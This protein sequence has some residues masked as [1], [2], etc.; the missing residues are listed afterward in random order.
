MSRSLVR[1]DAGFKDHVNQLCRTCYHIFRNIR[2]IRK[3]ITTDM[4]NTLVKSLVLNQLDYCNSIL[5]GLPDSEIRKLQ[6]VQNCAAKLVLNLKW[7]ES[8]SQ[9]L[10]TLNWLPIRKRIDF[11]IAV[12]VFK[13]VNNCAPRY[14]QELL[15]PLS[16]NRMSRSTSADEGILFQIPFCRRNT[17]YERSFAVSGPTVWNRL[18]SSVRCCTDLEVFRS[19]LKTHY[20]RVLEYHSQST[21]AP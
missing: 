13:C 5:Y 6:K 19:E 8:S 10:K 4:C 18:P 11:K 21:Q 20:F 14:L 7:S 16:F 9:A 3:F 17:F 12:L 2:S 15:T 1:F